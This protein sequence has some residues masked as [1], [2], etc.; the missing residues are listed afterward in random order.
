VNLMFDRRIP[1]QA[2]AADRCVDA[3]FGEVL[4]LGGSL[5]GEH[6]IGLSKRGFMARALDPVTL[7]LL[8]AI[9]RQFDPAGILNPGKLLPIS[10][11]P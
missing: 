1:A 7:D 5:S 9:K 6:G 11:P 4:A 10:Q 8:H 2:E 3:L